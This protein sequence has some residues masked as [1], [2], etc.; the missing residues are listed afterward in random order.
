MN[1]LGSTV[2]SAWQSFYVIVGSSAAALIGMQF[3]V[4]TLLANQRRPPTE[5]TVSAFGTPTVVHLASALLVS[6]IMSLPWPSLFPMTITLAL[7]GLSG[8]GYGVVV[9]R[10]ARRQTYYQPERADWLWYALFPCSTYAALMVA[11]LLLRATCLISL[12]A[13]AAAALG[14]LLI[15]IHNAWD[16]V[17]HIVV[18]RLHEDAGDPE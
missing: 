11:A 14:L 4:V 2:L 7:C 17:T 3:I 10:R 8:V 6:S 5:E 18:V 16:T 9:I 13:I 12:F 1:E 15:A